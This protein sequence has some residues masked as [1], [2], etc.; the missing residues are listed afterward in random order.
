MN[1]LALLILIICIG[2]NHK[3]QAQFEAKQGFI[4][5]LNLPYNSLSKGFDGE[6]ILVGTNDVFI[7]PKVNASFGWGV[8]LEIRSK[9]YSLELCY[10][11]SKHDVIWSN[12]SAKATY[13]VISID[14][15]YYILTRSKFQPFVQLGW[16]PAMPL[17]VNDGAVIV[18]SSLVSDAR[19]IGEIGNFQGGFGV[20]YYFS[21][22]VSVKA[23]ALYRTSKYRSVK[24]EEENVA[25]EIEDGL[26][27]ADFNFVFGVSYSF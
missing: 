18:S 14:Y 8:T 2:I 20:L 4:V 1:Y 12:T 10:L 21:P 19:Y 11:R 25:L 3:V 26:N 23:A 24:S 13:S 27:G 9:K 16:I 22:K 7:V 15:K 6:T 17:R 5:G